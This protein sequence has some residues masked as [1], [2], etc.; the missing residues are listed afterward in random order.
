MTKPCNW[1][2]V[3]A[4]N[5]DK[6]PKCGCYRCTQRYEAAQFSKRLAAEEKHDKNK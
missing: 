5:P 4:Y 3:A 1:E 6:L 2:K